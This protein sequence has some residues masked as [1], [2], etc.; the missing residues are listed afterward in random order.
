M[1]GNDQMDQ[2]A[3]AAQWEASLDSEDPAAAAA[4]AAKNELTENMALQWAAMV[5][6]GS[7]DFGSKTTNGERVLSQEEIDNLLG[8]TVGDVSLDDHSGIRAI[9]DSAMVSYERL[10]MLEI[11]FDRLVRLMTTSL[12]NFTSDNVE[13]SLDRITSVRFGDYMNSI[14]LPAV[15]SVFK[16][17]E[18]ENFGLATVDSSLIYSMIDVLLGGRRGQTQLRI[19]GRPYTTIE[20]NLVKR[21]V[22]VVL[23]DAE[24][25]FR[26]LSPVTFSIDRLETNPRFAAISRPANA[27]ILVRLRI[28]MEDRGG[29][30]E[31]LLP[32]ATIEPIRNVLLQMFMG[33]K[34]GRDPI[35]EGHFATEVAQAEI[36][37]D[38]VLYE[39]DIPLKELMKL[40]VGDT[41]PLDIRSDALV[42]VR[43]GNV[44]LTEGRMGRVG[45]RV[46]IRVTKNLRKP[47]TT[48]AMFE[49]AD[50]RTKMMEAP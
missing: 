46:A 36:A 17:E 20:T 5:E 13:V 43:C 26:P 23:S 47:Q 7:R 25:A 14:P 34:F 10:P 32:Y 21:L 11:V 50:E 4:E 40:K 33:E 49:K 39:A 15:L 18:W 8:F 37:V 22:E 3:I 16:A 24:Q 29:N 12:R 38:A 35:W 44:T 48:F 28:D 30:V 42:S 41:L 6:D 1:A 45:D 2:D 9:I 27:A 19:E 31:L